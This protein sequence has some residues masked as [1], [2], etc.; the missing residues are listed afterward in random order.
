MNNIS[1]RAILEIAKTLIGSIVNKIPIQQQIVDKLG[2][3]LNVQRC[4][5]FKL[6]NN[7][8]NDACNIEIELTAGIPLEEHI[9]DIGRKETIRKHPDIEE[10]VRGGKIMIITNPKSSPLATYFGE[11]IRQ[12]NIT[13]ILY[14]PLVS[15]L[16]DKTVGVIVVDTAEEKLG[17]ELEEIEFCSEVGELISLILDREEVLIKQMRDLIINRTAA[18]GGL[19]ARLAKLTQQVSTDAMKVIEEMEKMEKICPK[20]GTSLS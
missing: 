12:K 4:V 3:I 6:S 17:F 9:D 7:E 14:L 18:L 16:S 8:I 2:K 10:A 11:M 15:E 1:R 13:Q 5:I 19:A 20:S